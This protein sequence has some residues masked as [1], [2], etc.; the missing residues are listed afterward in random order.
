[1]VASKQKKKIL[2]FLLLF[3]IILKIMQSNAYAI[4]EINR[5][6]VYL[7]IVNRIS[8][9]DIDN[10]I[11]IKK[12]AL[13]GSIGLMN[14]RGINS[15]NNAEGYAAIGNSAKTFADYLSTECYN[16]DID[17]KS[18]YT[19]RMGQDIKGYKIANIEM[20]HLYNLNNNNTYSPYIGALGENLHKSGYSTAVFGN[21]DTADAI[22]RTGCL[23]AMDNKGLIDSGDV[24]EILINDKK[25]VLGK[26]T[27][28]DKIIKHIN[29]SD[30]DVTL[31]VI[32][33]GDINRL[34][35]CSDKLSK[36]S[37]LLEK[38]R[39]ISDIDMFLGNLIRIIDKS[40]SRIYLISPNKTD[41]NMQSSSKLSPTIIWGQQVQ[42]G[43]LY[44]RTT[45]QEGVIA[46]IDIAPSIT[47]YLNASNDRFTGDTI[48]FIAN[49]QNYKYIYELDNRINNL[50]SL[51]YPVL[52]NFAILG[53][54][55]LLMLS[56]L[57]IFNDKVVIKY[58]R[59]TDILLYIILFFP[60]VIYLI[61]GLTINSNLV[62]IGII[63]SL[64]FSTYMFSL[65]NKE[66]KILKLVFIIT[67]FLMIVDVAF[68]SNIIKNSVLGYDLII[69]ARF[70]GIGNESAGV[71]IVF[72][73]LTA[74]LFSRKKIKKYII[75]I[76]LL[77]SIFVI[78]NPHMGA[79]VGA[80]ISIFFGSIY[81]T[82]KIYDIKINFIKAFTFIVSITLI[83][84]GMGIIDIKTNVSPTHIGK[85]LIN[86][87]TYGFEAIN[88]I[89]IRKIN[90]N[91]R[92][93][94]VTI[95]FK[96]LCIN[97]F[98]VFLILCLLKNKIKKIIIFNKSM[99]IGLI[100]VFVAC[101][102]GFMVNDSGIVLASISNI[103]ATTAFLYVT[104]DY[105]EKQDA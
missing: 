11:N 17:T 72:C 73:L 102:M 63:I 1:M 3:I 5:R 76:M 92:L 46:N 64:F 94:S 9:D 26:R 52:S 20:N 4:E 91:I 40:R 56:L 70:F 13:E 12:L 14:T 25:Y 41:D 99:F 6:K 96:I 49:K 53:V 8:L 71:L 80:T 36:E 28:Y 87:K 78:A 100:S 33:C 18:T 44:T 77:L 34:Y 74:G 86:F 43:V 89:F 58:K 81:F 79:N 42:S 23:I 61:S 97:L 98:C 29:N 22:I 19:R 21:S 84:I 31:T 59:L 90:T 16:L 51:R 30:K 101:I 48:E 45:E 39:I 57:L 65:H 103:F 47:N 66:H 37:Y 38:R 2:L 27:N 104:I 69:G 55:I 82:S 35:S 67:Y 75:V 7:L 88:N 32:E 62:Y 83:V 50:S 24:D 15:Y 85:L 10:S 95:W 105:I 54:A 60:L 93:L 68:G